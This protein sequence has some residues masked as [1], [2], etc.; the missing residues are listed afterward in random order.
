V[1]KPSFSRSYHSSKR[2][3]YNTTDTFL[4]TMLVCGHGTDDQPVAIYPGGRKMFRCPDGCGLQK[5]KR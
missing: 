4:A 3:T 1:S 2:K 5:A